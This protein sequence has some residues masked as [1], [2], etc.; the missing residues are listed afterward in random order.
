MRILLYFDFIYNYYL[1][2]N[3]FRLT[4][5]AVA[6]KAAAAAAAVKAAIGRLELRAARWLSLTPLD[7]WPVLE[8]RRPA[9]M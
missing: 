4:S 8:K 3:F 6:A 5:S 2:N 7:G 9:D 1:Y